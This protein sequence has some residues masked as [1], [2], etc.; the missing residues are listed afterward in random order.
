MIS[1]IILRPLI[2]EKSMNLTKIGM[3]TFEVDK[4]ATKAQIEKIIKEKFKVDVLEVKTVNKKGKRRM[5]RSRRQSYFTDS[6]KKA[7]VKIKSGQKI[8]L[9]EQVAESEEEVSVTTAEGEPI[10]KVK[11]KKSLLGRT[12]V[13]IEKEVK[14]KG[15]EGDEGKKNKKKGE[16]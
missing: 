6:I 10:T 15:N 13:K 9:F 7:I 2:N 14:G 1:A 16:K 3:Y 4:K 11:E 5:Q 8:A 12:K